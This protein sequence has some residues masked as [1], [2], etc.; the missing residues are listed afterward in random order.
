[1]VNYHTGREAVV[2]LLEGTEIDAV[3][4]EDGDLTGSAGCNQYFAGYETE[5]DLITIGAPGA[6]RRFCAE[7]PGVMEQ[8]AAYVAA[9]ASAATWNISGDQ[10]QLR[11]AGDQL[12]VLMVRKEIVDLPELPPDSVT[13][14]GRVVAA[15]GLNIRSGPGTNFPVV[16]FARY[17]DE[18]E[19]TGRSADGR[20]WVT[21]LRG[22]ANGW[23]SADWVIASNADDV[24][25]VEAPPP[26]PV[27]PTPTRRPTT[28]PAPSTPTRV[29]PP[30][31]TPLPQMSFS[32][33]RTKI[34]AGECV[35]LSWSVEN[36]QAVWVYPQ[37]Q[38]YRNF[39]RAGQGSERVCPNATTTWEMRVLQRDG[40]VVVRQVTINVAQQAVPPTATIPAPPADP[41]A[42]TRWQVANYNNG[43]GAVVGLIEGTR[44]NMDFGTDGQVTGNAGCNNFFAAYRAGGDAINIGTPGASRMYCGA[45]E[46][47]MDQEADFLRALDSAVTFRIDGNRLELRGAGGELAVMATR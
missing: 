2:G 17:G 33:D 20:W 11:T 47:V 35:T 13:P 24:P 16:G 37:G 29:P 36:V 7:P 45:P 30:K 1:V 9:L 18:G 15:I 14:T 12:A 19:I 39:P 21:P 8:E 5:G 40:N 41:L 23:A 26:P 46:G 25:V 42:G 31:A 38:P 4:G 28:V 27:P 43:R 32:A 3:F 34:N 22:G 6:T 44:V 10:L